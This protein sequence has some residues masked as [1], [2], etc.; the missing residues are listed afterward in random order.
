MLE[1]ACLLCSE[2]TPH[3][4]HRRLVCDY[5]NDRWGGLLSVKHL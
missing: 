5:L 1:N 3:N 2:A 4:C